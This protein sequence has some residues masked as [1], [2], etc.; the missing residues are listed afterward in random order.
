MKDEDY[1]QKLS[2]VAEWFIPV[3]GAGTVSKKG[4]KLGRP[5]NE[6][7]YQAA[8]E[9]MFLEEFG[10][11]N[12]TLSLELVKVK[13]AAVDCPDCDRH[14]SEGRKVDI[15]ICKAHGQTY[16]RRR[17]HSC[18]LYEDPATNKFTTNGTQS[19]IKWNTFLSSKN[20]KKNT[21]S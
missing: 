8:R 20:S 12:S 14:C 19:S 10:G 13:I 11:V 5:T 9:K 16:F 1:K 18:N 21:G 7:K 17:C 6:D 15:K 2:E 4:G 3:V